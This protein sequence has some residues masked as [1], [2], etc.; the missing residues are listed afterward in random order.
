MVWPKGAKL[1]LIPLLMG[2]RLKNQFKVLRA[3]NSKQCYKNHYL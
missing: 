2:A 3:L 1:L